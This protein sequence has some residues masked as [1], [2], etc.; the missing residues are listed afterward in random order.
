MEQ[1]KELHKLQVQ[2]E[3]LQLKALQ[4]DLNRKSERHNIQLEHEREV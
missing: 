3:Q 2:R 1:Q 4:D